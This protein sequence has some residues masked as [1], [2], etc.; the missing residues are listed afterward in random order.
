M[1]RDSEIKRN[2]AEKKREMVLEAGPEHR[3]AA[4]CLWMKMKEVQKRVLRSHFDS[5]QLFVCLS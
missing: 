2:S 1:E 4:M 5:F 3:M